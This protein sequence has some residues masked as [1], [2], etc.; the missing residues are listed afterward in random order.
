MN[1]TPVRPSTETVVSALPRGVGAAGGEVDVLASRRPR[2]ASARAR[3]DRGHVE[4]GHARVAAER[5]DAHADDRDV[6]RSSSSAGA[7]A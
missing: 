6:G 4:A 3:G 2:R 5:M 7:K 1:G